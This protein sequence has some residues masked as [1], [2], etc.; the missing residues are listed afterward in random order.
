MRNSI[1]VVGVVLAAALLGGCAGNGLS[2]GSPLPS[3]PQSLM[4]QT[5][6]S[7]HGATPGNVVGGGP[8][9]ANVVGGGPRPA[10]VVGGGPSPA[11][12]VGGG[13]SP[14]NVVGGGPSPANVVGGG[15]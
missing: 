13:P 6:H 12:V 8:S 15:P 1:V 3:A 4:H 9:P 5:L 10:N 2:G 14:A 11:N 7:G